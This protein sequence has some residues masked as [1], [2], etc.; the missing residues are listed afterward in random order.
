MTAKIVITGIGVISPYGVGQEILW[1]KLIA[2]CSGINKLTSFDVSHIRCRAGGQLP[3]FDPTT[4]L[5]VRLARKLDRFSIFGLITAQ[6]AMEDAGLT[7]SNLASPVSEDKPA[8]IRHAEGRDRV[9]ITVGNNLGG[10]EF[11]ERE[12]YHLWEEGPR[13]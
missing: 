7:V 5:P 2:G 10:W 3:D 8:A 4:Y 1:E 12:L 6:Q 13:A 9:G 11:A